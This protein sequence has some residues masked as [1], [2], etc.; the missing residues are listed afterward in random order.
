M[1]KVHGLSLFGSVG[2][3]PRILS[4]VSD[5][6][7]TAPETATL[8]C[9]I[10]P[11]MRDFDVHW[12]KENKEVYRGRK[13]EMLFWDNRAS[14]VIKDSEPSDSAKYRCELST[15]LGRVQSVGSLIVYSEL[16]IGFFFSNSAT[17]KPVIYG[18]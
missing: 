14:L 4:N 10:K 12:F 17:V 9:A 15:P 8:D 16:I 13:Y 18:H 1:C 6:V 11:G 2:D 7:V 5:V 3:P